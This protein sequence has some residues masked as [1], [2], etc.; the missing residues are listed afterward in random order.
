MDGK[1]INNE[2]IPNIVGLETPLETPKIETIE[3]GST[4]TRAENVENL[5]E[6]NSN[7][8][9]LPMFILTLLNIWTICIAQLINWPTALFLTVVAFI[10][11]YMFSI[12]YRS[13]G[14]NQSDLPIRKNTR[15]LSVNKIP[16]TK[17]ENKDVILRRKRREKILRRKHKYFNKH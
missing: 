16:E 14:I 10:V 11:V 4:G 3:S 13:Y 6:F 15:I 7:C 8:F 2:F 1:F 12:G 9:Y 5:L 17:L